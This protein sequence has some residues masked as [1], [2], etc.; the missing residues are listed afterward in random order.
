[1]KYGLQD[2]K[3]ADGET[4]KSIVMGDGSTRV[5]SLQKNPDDGMTG[6]A[7]SAA[8]ENKTVGKY[9]DKDKVGLPVT[10][11]GVHTQLLFDNP[12]SIDVVI[13]QLLE[14]KE[15]LQEDPA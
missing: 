4:I 2:I 12:A 9:I 1:M 7:F 11:L 10:G 5:T 14:A 6:I 3:Y 8:P 13:G 15:Y